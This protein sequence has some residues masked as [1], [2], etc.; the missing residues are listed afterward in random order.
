MEV[1]KAG[2]EQPQPT[3]EARCEVPSP[4]ADAERN[5]RE[6]NPKLVK[7]LEASKQLSQ[8]LDNAAENAVRV[9][10]NAEQ[11]PVCGNSSGLTRLG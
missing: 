1:E 3:T 8:R 11:M 7:S 10:Q 6:W 2:H 5:R 9:L 4:G